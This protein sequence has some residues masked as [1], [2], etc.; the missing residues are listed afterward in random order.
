[1]SLS[2][3]SQQ[4]LGVTMDKDW[5]IRCSNWE[6][7]ELSDRQIQYAADDAIVA[8][9]IFFKLTASK[10]REQDIRIEAGN[11]KES[12]GFLETSSCSEKKENS[13]LTS[14]TLRP[15]E[16]FENNSDE[17][18]TS[19]DTTNINNSVVSPG[20][21]SK[22]ASNQSSAA[23]E[24][25][26]SDCDPSQSSSNE[27]D[28]K[29]DTVCDSK[30]RTNPEVGMLSTLV[31][32]I[33]TTFVPVLGMQLEPKESQKESTSKHKSKNYKQCESFKTLE[34]NENLLAS[35]R[36]WRCISPLCHGIVDVPYKIKA[37]NKGG[38]KGQNN[39]KGKSGFSA[40]AANKLSGLK[41]RQAPL[42]QNCVIE[43]PD[44]EMLSTCDKRKAEWYLCR[45]LGKFCVLIQK[46]SII[47]AGL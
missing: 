24:V 35:P 34:L 9:W 20:N 39:D 32:K 29:T 17:N 46:C 14:I 26:Q 47:L 5:K 30:E 8:V 12:E 43:A 25:S 36:F 42:Y 15:T 21:S 11:M 41:P 7:D 40:Q 16:S 27:S 37:K 4:V 23:N 1:M 28:P 18:I 33:R 31:S 38:G 10:L 3:L 6:A 2:A 19:K 45:D 13:Q 22:Q 44:G